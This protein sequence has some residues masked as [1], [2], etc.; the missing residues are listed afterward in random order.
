MNFNLPKIGL[1]D[2]SPKLQ[3]DLSTPKTTKSGTVD[4]TSSVK[5]LDK[6]LSSPEH[7]AKFKAKSQLSGSVPI[8]DPKEIGSEIE[9]SSP[10]MLKSLDSQVPDLQRLPKAPMTQDQ[11]HFKPETLKTVTVPIPESVVLRDTA[12]N[13]LKGVDSSDFHNHNFSDDIEEIMTAASSDPEFKKNLEYC[14]SCL[15]DNP[16]ALKSFTQDL[17]Q[18][19]F[20]DMCGAILVPKAK[21]HASNFAS[22]LFLN[23]GK[24]PTEK[25]APTDVMTSIKGSIKATL[26]SPEFVISMMNEAQKSGLLN[27]WSLNIQPKE[28]AYFHAALKHFL[29]GQGLLAGKPQDD[30][31]DEFQYEMET[32]NDNYQRALSHIESHPEQY[33]A[34]FEKMAVQMVTHKMQEQIKTAIVGITDYDP[35]TSSSESRSS[36]NKFLDT[37]KEACGQSTIGDWLVGDI[38]TYVEIATDPT[39]L[40]DFLNKLEIPEDVALKTAAK[41]KLLG[42]DEREVEAPPNPEEVD[43]EPV[44]SFDD[45][46]LGGDFDLPDLPDMPELP[47]SSKSSE[48]APDT[49]PI[50]KVFSQSHLGNQSLDVT[51]LAW[52]DLGTG[53]QPVL[54]YTLLDKAADLV[55]DLKS[56]DREAFKDYFTHTPQETALELLQNSLPG[57]G[58]SSHKLAL[59]T[60]L[61]EGIMEGVD[62]L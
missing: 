8:P 40:A 41:L 43:Y 20:G 27:L 16:E 31:S 53:D 12:E 61:Y 26:H 44:E 56:G 42:S 17:V 60:V 2:L 19:G 57:T 34:M 21:E 37:V 45:F 47:D 52:D 10:E 3:K 22:A 55:R 35:K 51:Q 48:V 59:A 62:D 24:P 25:T 23:G 11:F 36:Y 38:D 30:Y 13:L 7:E 9:K 54:K 6:T 58:S 28:S 14:L 32:I 18:Y 29:Q 15:Q 4:P 33:K 46:D 50:V 39:R 49:T 1:G 5:L